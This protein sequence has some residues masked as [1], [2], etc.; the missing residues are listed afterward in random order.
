M[1]RTGFLYD[2]R[3]LLHSTGPH[4]PEC[5]DRLKA[6]YQG[7]AAG[8]LLE[9][10]HRI[11]ASVPDQR[12]IERVHPREYI[13]RFQEACLNGLREFDS[14]DNQMCRETFHV[15]LL[16][17][18]GILETVDRVMRGDLDNA[19]CAV[20]P[21]GHHAEPTRAMGFCYFNNIAIAARYI[22]ERWGLEKVGII[23]FDVHHGNGTQLIFEDDPTVFYYSI[24]EHP[25]FS[26]PGTGR[27]F[28]IG[29]GPGRGTIR[30][31]PV[32]PGISDAEYLE[33][34]KPEISRLFDAFLPQVILVSTG[35]DAHADDDMADLKLSTEAFTQIIRI[36]KQIADR[37]CTGRLISILEGGYCLQHLPELAR[38]HV[39]VLLED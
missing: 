23:D 1:R 11:T 21:P 4:H 26:Y 25:S 32:I 7:I 14:P 22:Q 37:L 9:K 39:S 3:Y 28:D 30:N 16:A 8:G 29:K 17:V 20:R 10:V 15:A 12:W 19:F 34:M 33:L 6:V 13:D 27:E 18:G 2:D 5:P 24:H 31:R 35:F 38:N 36:I